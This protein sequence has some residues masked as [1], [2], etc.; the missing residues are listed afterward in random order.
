MLPQRTMQYRYCQCAKKQER[1]SSY[2]RTSYPS[3]F[4]VD[5]RRSSGVTLRLHHAGVALW[6]HASESWRYVGPIEMAV[7]ASTL[8]CRLSHRKKPPIVPTTISA[9]KRRPTNGFP[10]L[11]MARFESVRNGLGTSASVLNLANSS[12]SNC[13]RML[14]LPSS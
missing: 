11:T 3:S 5:R 10:R 14:Y 1:R 7:L 9:P 12:E 6:R 2:H 4:H 8:P 13:D